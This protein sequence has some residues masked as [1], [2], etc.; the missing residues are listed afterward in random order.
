MD[1]SLCGCSVDYPL[2][3][4]SVDSP[5]KGPKLR[6]AFPCQDFL[7]LLADTI[8]GAIYG[9]TELMM[10]RCNERTPLSHWHWMTHMRQLTIRPMVKMMACISPDDVLSN[11]PVGT[12]FREIR[13]NRKQISPNKRQLNMSSQSAKW[14][15]FVPPLGRNQQ[16]EGWYRDPLK[17]PWPLGKAVEILKVNFP[18]TCYVKFLSDEYHII[19][20]ICQ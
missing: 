3:G 16:T 11:R 15:P 20:L 2:S 17:I 4:W 13:N 8:T 18:T 6:N 9:V 5:Y 1:C 19:P 12:I 10:M 14:R 7:M